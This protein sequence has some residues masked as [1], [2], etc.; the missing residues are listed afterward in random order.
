MKR[1]HLHH[2]LGAALITLV[3]TL[4]FDVTS[5]FSIAIGW[6]LGREIGQFFIKRHNTS[7]ITGHVVDFL[8]AFVGAIVMSAIMTII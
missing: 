3:I 7:H 6:Y 5:G 1:H 4:L 8:W 2:M